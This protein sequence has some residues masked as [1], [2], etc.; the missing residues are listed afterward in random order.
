MA[1]LVGATDELR[2]LVGFG[3]ARGETD[4]EEWMKEI[5]GLIRWRDRRWRRYGRFGG[6]VKD[7]VHRED[8]A[9][10]IGRSGKGYVS[11]E[12]RGFM[13]DLLTSSST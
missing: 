12:E 2:G 10:R 9:L 8:A 5:D 13:E 1:V 3:R 7:A 6:W 11:G 4:G